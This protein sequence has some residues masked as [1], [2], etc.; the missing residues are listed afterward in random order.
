MNETLQLKRS[1]SVLML[2]LYGLG[3]ILGAGIYVLVGKV[4]GQA[5][6]YAPVSFLVASLIVPFTALS[7]AELASRYPLSAGEVIYIYKGTGIRWLASLTGLLIMLA[8]I[9]S[10]ATITRGFVGYLQVFFPLFEPAAI[11]IVVLSIGGIAI[12]GIGEA[13]TISGLITIVEV[14]GLLFII[15]IGADS[16]VSLPERFGELIPPPDRAIW[17]GI[18]GGSFLAF[19]AFIG[20][21]DMVNVAEEIIHPETALPK[22]ILI[23]LVIATLLYFAVALVAILTVPPDLL[24]NSDAPLAAVYERATGEKPVMITVLSLFAVINGA[25]I[26]VIM[27]SR[28]L[29]GMSRQKWL[30]ELFGRIN[31]KTRTPVMATVVV[32]LLLLLFALWLPLEQLARSTSAIILIVFVFV[33]GSLC[34]VKR[35]TP[36]PEGIRTYPFWIPVCGTILNLGLLGVELF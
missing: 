19:Y 6:M 34:L 20:F 23:S 30:P 4:A 26:Q 17:Y 2:T 14:F 36:R 5:G 28:I 27:A 33:N 12:R 9:V 16:L 29:Y 22:G 25:L 31:P 1:L 21:E 10:A 24:K 11:T 8:G 15:A 32:T 3:N 35:K 18:L 7:Y 13:V